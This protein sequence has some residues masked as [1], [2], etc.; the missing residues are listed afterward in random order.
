MVRLLLFVFLCTSLF[1]N[2][3]N[4]KGRVNDKTNDEPLVGATVYLKN[5]P[6]GTS[7]ALDGTFLLKGISSG[8][9]IVVVSMVG[10]KQIEKPVEVTEG[11]DQ[12]MTFSLEE[13][14]NELGEIIVT[15]V[16]ENESDLSVRRAEQKAD[17]VVNI[18]SAKSI[19]L[20]PDLTVGNLL[21]RVSGVS[22]VR[23]G[24][25]DGQYA[26][27][28]GMD[29]RY[30]YTMVNG[31]KIPSP[32]S[33]N[34]YVPL[35]IFPADLLE[36]LEV[37]KALTPSMEGDGIGGAMN[38]VMKS[39]PSSLSI[40]ATLAGGYSNILTAI[41]P[42]SG[43]STSNL[44]IKSPEELYGPSYPAKASDFGVSQLQYTNRSMP[45]NTTMSFSIGNRVLKDKLGFIIASSY[46]NIYRGTNSIFYT[47]NQPRTDPEPN[48]Y[49]FSELQIRQFNTLQNRLGLHAKLDYA[50]NKNNKISLYNL[51][52]KLDEAQ[53]RNYY[54]PVNVV[55]DIHDR[56]RFTT[57]N[58]YT[59]S[60]RGDHNLFSKLKLDWTF[61][62]SNATSQTPA[63]SDMS[64][65]YTYGN[66]GSLL[67]TSL[68]SLSQQWNHN[69]DNDKTGYLNF[70]YQLSKILEI[71]TGGFARFKNR[72]NV[73]ASYTLNPVTGN[74]FISIDKASFFLSDPVSNQADGNNYTAK[75][76]VYAFYLQGKYTLAERLQ[77]IGG[78]RLENT[79]LEWHSQ[80]SIRKPGRDGNK[81]YSNPLPSLN[82][83][84]SLSPRQNVRLS[85]YKALSR[86]SFFEVIPIELSG[87]NWTDAGN[88][89]LNAATADSYDARYE[90]FNKG[91]D[92]I[93]AG[94]FY[95]RI[96]DAIEYTFSST[97]V[98]SGNLT[99]VNAGTA[100]NYGFELVISKYIKNFGVSANYTY[101]NS[102]ITTSKKVFFRDDNGN[103]TNRDENQ[104]RPLQGQSNHIGN[105]S[106]IYKNSKL[107]FD[108]QLSWVYTG[109]RINFV[110]PYKDLD[111]WQ[112]DFS[113][114]DF[115]CEKRIWNKL[116]YF[117]KITNLLDAPLIVEIART[118]TI[119]ADQPGQDS[120]NNIVVQ[121][122]DFH[123]TFLT[124]LRYKF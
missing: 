95:K 96:D 7:V 61:T 104:A 112:R 91:N 108:A 120:R 121:K 1:A 27:I 9:Y 46:Q 59:T 10:Y 23:N 48:T 93:L 94:V 98:S 88:P 57:Q 55:L 25:G 19:Q 109:R 49:A 43:Y 113:Q 52:V 3:S 105:V 26:I 74:T 80:L 73:R 68:A 65:R 97:T 53:H 41:R 35:D 118:N 99:P 76:N 47:L 8:S 82:L 16:A 62:Y 44:A 12:N 103:Q 60:M 33:K 69:S 114:L 13:N 117:L 85:Y 30:T 5:T 21:Q 75:E 28:R 119:N 56:S 38:M 110:S 24:S 81:V 77:V 102:S 29:K 83:K 50:I 90:F 92:Q 37:S 36:R 63:W 45:I 79:N 124:G 14:A 71:S 6:H 100:S 111:Y 64:V 58:I 15:G 17:N 11:K 107:G 84:Y 42:F 78:L 20:L 18:M 32:D 122:D 31:I 34:R 40:S 89:D 86:P 70:N 51:F 116:Q 2:A 115:S 72:D 66:D 101:T 22:I 67:S 39:A 4:L 106:F 54:N 123:Q 87:D